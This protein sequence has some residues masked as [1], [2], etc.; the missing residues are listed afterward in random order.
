MD[1]KRKS[2]ERFR[3]FKRRQMHTVQVRSWNHML[4]TSENYKNQPTN[5]T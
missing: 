3:D 4:Q 1:R 2:Q 5:K